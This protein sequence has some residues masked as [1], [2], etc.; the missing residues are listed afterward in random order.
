MIIKR[1]MYVHLYIRILYCPRRGYVGINE[2]EVVLEMMR[3]KIL[4]QS[5][6]P[7]SRNS[8]NHP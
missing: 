3:M 6:N 1:T 4:L 8:V 7:H 2:R 5:N